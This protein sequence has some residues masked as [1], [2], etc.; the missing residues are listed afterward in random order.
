M[1][2]IAS[3]LQGSGLAASISSLLIVPLS[4]SLLQGSRL[5]ASISSLLS[6]LI[7]AFSASTLPHSSKTTVLLV[8]WEQAVQRNEV[9]I[10]VKWLVGIPAQ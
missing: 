9:A 5:A 7:S 10:V 4:R 1:T 8:V 6:S 2:Q 3:L